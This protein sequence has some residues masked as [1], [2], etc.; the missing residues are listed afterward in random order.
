MCICLNVVVVYGT[1]ICVH[2]YGVVCVVECCLFLESGCCLLCCMW[3]NGLLLLYFIV[4]WTCVVECLWWLN[5]VC[6]FS[7]LCVCLC[8]VYV[9][10]YVGKLYVECVCG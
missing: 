10:D 5:V 7:Y 4:S 3:C 1:G 8:Y 2:L 9:F 6:V